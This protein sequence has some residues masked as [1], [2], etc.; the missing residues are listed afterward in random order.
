ME[1]QTTILRMRLL[2]GFATHTV[3]VDRRALSGIK[4]RSFRDLLRS[5][6]QDHERHIEQ[7][8]G[9]VARDG[10]AVSERVMTDPKVVGDAMRALDVNVPERTRL[11]VC[12]K[13]EEHMAEGYEEAIAEKHSLDIQLIPEKHLADELRHIS[14]LDGLLADESAYGKA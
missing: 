5:L 4:S 11:L 3:E 6:I 2:A 7:L 13:W 1:S 14:M 10:G 8:L 9:F 12:Q